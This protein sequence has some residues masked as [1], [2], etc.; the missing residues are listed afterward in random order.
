[1]TATDQ[2]DAVNAPNIHAQTLNG[3]CKEGFFPK[4]RFLSLKTAG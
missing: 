2:P 4:Y 3:E 1:M